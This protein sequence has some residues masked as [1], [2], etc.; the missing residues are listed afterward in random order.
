MEK[1]YS[2]F[3]GQFWIMIAGMVFAFLGVVAKSKCS[4]M[5]CCFGMFA[6]KRDVRLEARLEEDQLKIQHP[7]QAPHLGSPIPSISP[8]NGLSRTNTLD[9][10]RVEV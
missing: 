7:A 6:I 10:I 3:N 9:H 2:E 8:Q 5:T 1:W 4:D